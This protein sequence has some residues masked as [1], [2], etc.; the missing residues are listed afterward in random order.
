MCLL[1]PRAPEQW[2]TNLCA[3]VRRI[4]EKESKMRKTVLLFALVLLVAGSAFAADR[5]IRGGSDLW[6]TPADGGTFADFALE[7]IPA[8]FFCPG[9]APF[10]GQI[11]FKGVPL[12]TDE[13][14]ALGTTDT[15]IERL[16]DAMFKRGV[17]TTRIQI[18]ALSLESVAPFK[19]SCGDYKAVVT[20]TGEQPVTTMRILRD[21]AKGGRFMAPLSV[22]IRTTFIP[23][24]RNVSNE[25]LELVQTINF[26]VTPNAWSNGAGLSRL[27]RKASVVVDTDGDNVPDA[28]VRGT[29]NFVGAS[30]D[31][32]KATLSE[33]KAWHTAP[34]HAHSPYPTYEESVSV[35][36]D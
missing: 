27:E 36:A 29:S 18:R 11:V 22:N 35:A 26:D 17:A 1:F 20:L 30:R 25:K 13:P 31:R 24:G 15:I 14:G 10:T 7:P 6:T 32:S 8:G 5:V 21:N 9:S 28:E 2:S 4:R 19:T 3:L 12:V 33:A 34:T 16:D 23:V